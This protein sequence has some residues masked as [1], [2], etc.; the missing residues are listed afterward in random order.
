MR[1]KYKAH[2]HQPI[3]ANPRLLRKASQQKLRFSW[4]KAW[5]PDLAAMPNQT[6][7]PKPT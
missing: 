1:T 7:T 2:T 3:S 4:R 5:L 6:T